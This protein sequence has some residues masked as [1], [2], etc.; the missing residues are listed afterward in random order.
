MD[1][2]R[3]CLQCNSTGDYQGLACDHC[4]GTGK[5]SFGEIIEGDGDENLDTKLDDVLGKCSDILDKCNDIFEKV[6]E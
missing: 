2:Y 1:V 5:I 3:K 6:S 4:N